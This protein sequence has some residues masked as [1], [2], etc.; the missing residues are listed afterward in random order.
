MDGGAGLCAGER[1]EEGKAEAGGEE[2][3]GEEEEEEEEEV[4][5]EEGCA[6]GREEGKIALPSRSLDS[7]VVIR[8]VRGSCCSLSVSTT[9]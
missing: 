7:C 6:T 1:L 5:E 9:I 4:T 3:E 2:T 8:R